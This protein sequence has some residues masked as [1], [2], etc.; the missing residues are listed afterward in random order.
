MREL[1]NALALTFSAFF[2]TYPLHELMR[3]Y[4]R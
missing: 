2:L 1:L 4:H 3:R